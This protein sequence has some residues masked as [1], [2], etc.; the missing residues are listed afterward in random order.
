MTNQT[1]ISIDQAFQKLKF[2]GN[3]TAR[4]SSE[5]SKDAFATLA[6]YRDGAV[7]IGHYAGNSEWERHPNGDELVMVVAGET[8]LILLTGGIETPH[9]L[10]ESEFLVVPVNTWHRFETPAGVKVLT[11]TPQP[12]D[13]SI[14]R[15]DDH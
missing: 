6:E 4:T 1:P 2:L 3:R 11:V 15:P 8:T 7:F 14:E 12:T 5:E 10:R 13:H 9:T